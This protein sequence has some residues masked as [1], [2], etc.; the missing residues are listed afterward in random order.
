M[1]DGGAKGNI[2]NATPGAGVA[3]SVGNYAPD[4]AMSFSA[5]FAN[6]NGTGTWTLFVADTSVGGQGSLA[7]WGLDMEVTAVPEP[8]NVALGW[9]AGVV[10]VGI[11]VRS[12]RVR[13]VLRSV[14]RGQ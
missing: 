7:S 1:L 14:V 13:K 4:S 6:M 10:M 3:V 5:V 2:H 8:V 12:G 11:L 9:F